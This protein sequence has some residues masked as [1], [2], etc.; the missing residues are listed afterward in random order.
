MATIELQNTKFT[1]SVLPLKL[2]SNGFWARLEI[3]IENAYV[4]YKRIYTEITR[5]DLNEWIFCMFRLL[6]GAY[7]KDHSLIFESAGM[8][9]D[10]CPYRKAGG[11][12]S[13]QERRENDCA[14]VIGLRMIDPLRKTY[15]GGVQT[16]SLRR[17]D[18]ETFAVELRK[19]F[20]AVF[21]QHEMGEGKYLFAGVSP[22]GYRGCN[23]W[24][25]D[26]TQS[27]RAGE[28]VWV[29]MGRHNTEQIVYVDSVKYFSDADA[30][31][32]P[33]RVKQILRKATEEEI[34]NI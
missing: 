27:V 34:K 26:P 32:S 8:T 9:L 16:F 10:F 25:F 14:M 31:Y 1:V 11:A 13:R 7:G 28:Y 15:L 17:R 19:E 3:G 29:R 30:P 12:P 18:L 23:Y 5:A 33:Q 6:A 22:L 21:S 4:H 24:Y 20:N 2:L